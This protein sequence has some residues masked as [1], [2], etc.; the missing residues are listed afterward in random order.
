MVVAAKAGL[1]TLVALGFH[2]PKLNPGSGEKC[3][4]CRWIVELWFLAI[5]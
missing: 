1:E 5:H 3:E 4:T 2:Q